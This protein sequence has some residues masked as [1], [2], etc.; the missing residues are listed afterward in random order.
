M[1]TK[2][3]TAAELLD[4]APVGAVQIAALASSVAAGIADG[5]DNQALG[6][7]APTMAREWHLPAQRMAAAFTTGLIGMMFGSLLFGYLAERL[8]RRLAFISAVALLGASTLAIAFCGSVPELSLVRFFVGL[9]LGGLP[10]VMTSSVTEFAPKRLRASFGMWALSGIAL[11]GLVGA[12]L[13]AVM[14][15]NTG[16]KSVYWLGGAFTIAA[17]FAAY[18]VLPESISFLLWKKKDWSGASRILKRALGANAEDWNPD[19]EHADGRTEAVSIVGVFQR[20]RLRMTILFWVLQ[21]FLLMG[22]YFLVNWIPTLLERA[23]ASVQS[24]LF[25]SVVLNAGGTLSGLLVGRLIDRF[26][27]K[28]VMS[29]V[30]AAGGAVLIFTALAQG[31][32]PLLMTGI[33]L[34]GATWLAGQAAMVVFVAESYPAPIRTTSVGWTL[35]VGRIGAIVSPTVVAL[36]LSW[37][38]GVGAILLVPV[39]PAI[40]S[41]VAVHYAKPAAAAQ[42]ATRSAA[43]PPPATRS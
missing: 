19:L 16:W 6:F 9:S 20:D 10:A 24:A 28:H 23:G 8:G 1:S 13:A 5:F 31:D 29:G 43:L 3:V 40:L 21:A 35:T 39:L 11:G 33:F 12:L 26:G 7:T 22:Y 34:A 27:A 42:I 25:G 36:P 15:P 38:W 17:T 4:Q 2:P 30:F 37:G 32:T 18:F 41:A 14:V